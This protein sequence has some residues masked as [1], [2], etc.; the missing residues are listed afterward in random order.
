MITGARQVGKSTLLR[1]TMPEGMGYVTPDDYVLKPGI[2]FYTAA[3]VLP[4]KEGAVAF[5]ISAL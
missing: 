5:P 4:L 2:V 3:S 1:E